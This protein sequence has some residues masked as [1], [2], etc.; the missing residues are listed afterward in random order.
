MTV[1]SF[2][3]KMKLRDDLGK[4]GR[5]MLLSMLPRGL[6][7]KIDEFLSL[8]EEFYRRLTEIVEL[9]KAQLK[10]PNLYKFGIWDYVGL[11]QDYRSR[12]TDEE[13]KRLEGIG[14]QIAKEHPQLISESKDLLEKTQRQRREIFDRLEDFLKTNNLRLE[15][16]PER[17][18]Y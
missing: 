10:E 8:H 17:S 9:S 4:Y 5:F 14:Q 6:L 3:S 18:H 7:R 12:H 2:T 11:K 16:E 1:I 13:E 15:E